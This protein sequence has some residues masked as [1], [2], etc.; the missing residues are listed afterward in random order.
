MRAF[1][2]DIFMFLQW[3]INRLWYYIS[4][5]EHL[6]THQLRSGKRVGW[7]DNRA[8]TQLEDSKSGLLWNARKKQMGFGQISIFVKNQKCHLIFVSQR[9]NTSQSRCI[10]IIPVG[11]CALPVYAEVTESDEV[12]GDKKRQSSPI[13]GKGKMAIIG[14]NS[15]H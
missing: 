14:V 2:S 8:P 15:S 12:G 10:V 1:L 7:V 13:K 5:S 6:H 3:L 4:R 9:K 11:F